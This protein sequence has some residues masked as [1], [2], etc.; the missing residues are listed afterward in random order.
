[1]FVIWWSVLWLSVIVRLFMNR[2][3][4][5]WTPKFLT[6]SFGMLTDSPMVR[7]STQWQ[8]ALEGNTA[9]IFDCYYFAPCWTNH[10]LHNFK[11]NTFQCSVDSYMSVY[12]YSVLGLWKRRHQQST[13]YQWTSHIAITI[14]TGRSTIPN[15]FAIFHLVG[16]R[17]DFTRGPYELSQ[18]QITNYKTHLFKVAVQVS[19]KYKAKVIST[20]I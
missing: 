10:A 16:L 18:L 11:P 3:K 12:S 13:A 14:L 7:D 8:E 4:F 1:M 9:E 19:D 2:V 6:E 5:I 15:Q 20:L 17:W